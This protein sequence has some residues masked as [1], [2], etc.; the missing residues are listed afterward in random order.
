MRR[1]GMPVIA[2]AAGC[3]FFALHAALFDDVWKPMFVF[4]LLCGLLCVASLLFWVRGQWILSFAMF[5]LAYKS[6]ELAVMLPAALLCYELMFGGQRW[7]QLAL[8]LA[9]SAWWSLQALLLHPVTDNDYTFHFTAATLAATAPFYAGRIF[10]TPYPI[11][12]P[13]A[14]VAA[15]GRRTWFGL[16]VMALFFFPLLWLPGR[17]FSAYCYLPFTGLAI[18]MGGIAE[19][20]KP[21]V[22]AAFF[23]LWAPLDI[24]SLREQ[25][26]LTLSQDRDAREWLTTLA[27]FAETK[28]AVSGFVFK[29]MPDGFRAWGLEGGVKYF[30]RLLDVNVPPVDTPEGTQVLRNGH[31]AVLTWDA[32][33][34]RLQIQTVN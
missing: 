27:S 24:Y 19:H 9:A 32:A 1:L 22:I 20:V 10:L 14:A 13:L 2:A 8:F 29:G 18:A 12:L 6:K 23:L 16:A 30:F 3:A 11:L 26:N 33:G 34:H 15:G 21:A 4:D 7:K 31:A 5:W 28:P 25:R 17:I